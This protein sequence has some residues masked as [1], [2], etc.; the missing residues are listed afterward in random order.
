MTY[1]V[2]KTTKIESDNE[3]LPL[4]KDF[5][6][7]NLLQ[8]IAFTKSASKWT[9]YEIAI[10]S[11]EDEIKAATI[12]RTKKISFLGTIGYI[13][14]GPLWK[15][16]SQ[17]SSSED[18][19]DNLASFLKQLKNEYVD[20]R[21]FF[22]ILKPNIFLTDSVFINILDNLGYKSKKNSFSRK[23]LLIDLE[24]P[25]DEIKL[26]FRA[27]WRN[28]LNKVLKNNLEIKCNNNDD[29]FDEFISLY[30]QMRERKN[31]NES[32]DVN[33][34]KLINQALPDLYKMHI[35]VCYKNKKP[36][37]AI[38][39]TYL[40]NT[41]TYYLGASSE[42]GLS[43]GAPYLLQWEAI[44]WGKNIGA[45]WYD[46]G[47]IDADSNPGGYLFK[48]GMSKVEAQHSYPFEI[49]KINFLNKLIKLILNIKGY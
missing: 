49:Y 7:L 47:G 32:V 4:V 43:L 36:L 35:C 8:T 33:T 19:Y 28:Y 21:G 45:K 13:S 34:T 17:S 2:F 38:I 18:S 41:V 20:K 9:D 12:I 25:L 31:F 15:K 24:K 1:T 16:K 40:G 46:L 5:E 23:T 11:S 37:A 29:L 27:K 26:N 22:V 42:E 48:S 44:N 6:D 10:L 39:L 30:N 3:W 14:W